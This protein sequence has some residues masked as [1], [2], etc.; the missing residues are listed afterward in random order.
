MIRYNYI[1]QVG[2]RDHNEDYIK[3][4]VSG[5][6]ACFV[7]A[8]GLGGHGQGE[9]AS[10]FVAETIIKEFKENYSNRFLEK[11]ITKAQI[12]LLNYQKINNCINGMKTTIVVLLVDNDKIQ[13]AHVGDSRLYFWGK[14]RLIIR[15]LDHSVPQLLVRA[16]EL[17]EKNIRFHED[18]NKLLRVLG[19]EIGQFE[20]EISKIITVNKKKACLLCSDGFWE[21]IDE[22]RMQYSYKKSNTPD[23]WIKLMEEIVVKNGDGRAMDNYSAIAVWF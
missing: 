21:N 8:D 13:W 2:N 14:Q 6:R 17:K 9:V 10:Q 18:R 3:F 5:N 1:S 11:S 16:G 20:P 4:C 7:L 12:E 23:E 15:T 22:K 19:N